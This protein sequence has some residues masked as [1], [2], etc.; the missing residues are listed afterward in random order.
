MKDYSPFAT[1]DT[2]PKDKKKVTLEEMQV[3][4]NFITYMKGIVTKDGEA[5]KHQQLNQSF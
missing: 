1:N 3:R 5:S 2:T 4:K